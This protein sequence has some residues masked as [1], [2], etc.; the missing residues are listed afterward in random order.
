MEKEEVKRKVGFLSSMPFDAQTE[1]QSATDLIEGGTRIFSFSNAQMVTLE[2]DPIVDEFLVG[3]GVWNAGVILCHLLDSAE[4]NLLSGMRV[5]D[6]GSG[7]GIV[8]IVAARLGCESL[9]T[10]ITP[11]LSL[12]NSNTLANPP[13][14]GGCVNVA[15]LDWKKSASQ[16]PRLSEIYGPFEIVLGAD[17]IYSSHNYLP[18]MNTLCLL[19]GVDYIQSSE[20]PIRTQQEIIDI[21]ALFDRVREKKESRIEST[22][23]VLISWERRD[24]RGHY[25]FEELSR[26][27]NYSRV[28]CEWLDQ[29]CE[30]FH[31]EILF[32]EPC[33]NKLSL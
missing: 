16:L 15:E 32:I 6:I 13:L 33:T 18:L 29:L 21:S 3:N 25:F 28:S 20:E 26:R 8:G 17:L 14:Y 31:I 9:C 7:T 22:P 23:I 12:L 10:D 1:L 11:L 5:I 19:T 4:P 27:F 2:Q 24:T 30:H